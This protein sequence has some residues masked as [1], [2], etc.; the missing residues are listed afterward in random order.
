[1]RTISIR[2]TSVHAGASLVLLLVA[3]GA[4]ADAPTAD[5][6]PGRID[7]GRLPARTIIDPGRLT[8][9]RLTRDSIDPGKLNPESPQFRSID[10]GHAYVPVIP[11][12][13]DQP[14]R[15]YLPN[16]GFAPL[17]STRPT[18]RRYDPG[19]LS[20]PRLRIA[21][22]ITAPIDP[23][24]LKRPTI[25]LPPIDPGPLP[26]QGSQTEFRVPRSTIFRSLP[27]RNTSSP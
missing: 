25:L 17:D 9:Q 3:H 24:R 5:I 2:I 6:D 15:L 12:R 19:A 8:N 18:V 7:P 22:P 21:P 11:P 14:Q 27:G 4:R 16:L 13:W 20:A 1:M 10:P 23:G 26:R